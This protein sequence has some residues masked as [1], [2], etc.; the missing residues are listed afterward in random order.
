[1]I[2]DV[3]S[4]I[5]RNLVPIGLIIA[6]VI[7]ADLALKGK[8]LRS[9]RALLSIFVLVWIAAEF[10]RALIVIGLITPTPDLAL[11]G[12]MAHT[13]SMIVFGV[14]IVSQ[15]YK[16]PI[17]GAP[18]VRAINE[19]LDESLG[20][21]AARALKFY[22]E[23]SIAARNIAEFT[24]SLRKILTV[25]EDLIEKKI[26]AKLYE[27]VGLQFVEKPGYDLAKYVQEAQAKQAT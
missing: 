11:L 20:E 9:L 23:P 12:F 2:L 21:G 17:S 13:L 18:L 26:A 19:G 24:N 22:V 25:G 10:P 7:F 27:N 16:L 5:A 3:I 14:I 1:M 15:F 4:S 8:T 6:F